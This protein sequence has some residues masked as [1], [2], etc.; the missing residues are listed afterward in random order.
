MDVIVPAE[1]PAASKAR[2][3]AGTVMTTSTRLIDT[4]SLVML[5]CYNTSTSAGK[6]LT[7]THLY[8]QVFSIV[9][10]CIEYSSG[11]Y[12]LSIGSISSCHQISTSGSRQC[13][14]HKWH[15][16]M[17]LGDH[18]NYCQA[19]DKIWMVD[20]EIQVFHWSNGINTFEALTNLPLIVKNFD[21][22]FWNVYI[23]TNTQLLLHYIL[24]WLTLCQFYSYPPDYLPVSVK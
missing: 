14:I 18:V 7:A 20:T 5:Y 4:F 13:S 21:T 22:D 9:N 15:T 16:Y 1:G 8:F 10:L 24:L 12:H 19:T 2:L 6:I 23:D 3:S 11:F 17:Q